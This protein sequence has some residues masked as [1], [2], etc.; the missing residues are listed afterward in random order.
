MLIKA[1]AEC[2]VNTLTGNYEASAMVKTH[3]CN[4]KYCLS[5]WVNKKVCLE[6]KLNILAQESRHL[7]SQVVG[8]F[9]VLCPR[10]WNNHSSTD[11]PSPQC[12]KGVM[13]CET[14]L[15]KFFKETMSQLSYD[16]QP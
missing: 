9:V 14:R 2:V 8:K 5:K 6:V 15:C 16:P 12:V 3:L 1:L 13:S 4:Y 10:F 11:N 7:C